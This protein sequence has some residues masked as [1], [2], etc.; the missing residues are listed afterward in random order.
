MP[1]NGSPCDRAREIALAVNAFAVQP[2][3]W[4]KLREQAQAFIPEAAEYRQRMRQGHGEGEPWTGRTPSLAA[5]CALLAEL[6]DRYL[7]GVPI[8][9]RAA[10]ADGSDDGPWWAQTFAYGWIRPALKGDADSRSAEWLDALQA[11]LE[12]VK[13]A[14]TASDTPPAAVAG[15]YR[16][17]AGKLRQRRAKRCKDRK[18]GRSRR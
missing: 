11:Y 7:P 15:G 3:N 17:H 2:G 10:A 4:D 6:H 13:V 5:K 12:D 8:L 14:L 16:K 1:K 9:E 18:G